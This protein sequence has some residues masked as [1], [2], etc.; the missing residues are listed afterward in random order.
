MSPLRTN[1]FIQA[2][3]YLM[4]ISAALHVC[5]LIIHFIVTL[6]PSSLNLFEIIGLNLFY[7][8][9]VSSIFGNY[10]SVIVTLGIYFLAY[11]FLTPKK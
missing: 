8:V 7:P 5:I 2:F 9:F 11:I 3:L 10:L 6:D 1:R 4:L